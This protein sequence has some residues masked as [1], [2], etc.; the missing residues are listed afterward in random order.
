VCGEASRVLE[1]VYLLWWYSSTLI[2]T[3]GKDFTNRLK[4]VYLLVAAGLLLLAT[5]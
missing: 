4:Q 3:P 5:F 1:G 2:K